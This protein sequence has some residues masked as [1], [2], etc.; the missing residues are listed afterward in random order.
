MQES[1]FIGNKAAPFWALSVGGGGRVAL[2]A[3]NEGVFCRL[4]LSM[5]RKTKASVMVG[6]FVGQHSGS[7]RS[8]RFDRETQRGSAGWTSA[9]GRGSGSR[10]A[11]WCP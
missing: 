10:A 11:L 1:S 7:G 3:L 4:R 5:Q 6:A 8:R 2:A 9:H